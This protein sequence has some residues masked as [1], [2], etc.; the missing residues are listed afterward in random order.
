MLKKNVQLYANWVFADG[1]K[2]AARALGSCA[3]FFCAAQSYWCNFRFWMIAMSFS[4]YC[5][6][7]A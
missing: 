1:T 2:K 4:P 7:L 3:A 5:L 6:S